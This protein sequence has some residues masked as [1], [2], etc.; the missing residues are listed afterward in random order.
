MGTALKEIPE[1]RVPPPDNIVSR[2]INS[3]TG[4]ST[5]ENDPDSF[6]EYFVMGTEPAPLIPRI[7]D[8]FMTEDRRVV[9]P[10]PVANLEEELF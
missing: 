5:L 1:K 2:L 10:K 9:E 6:T 7:A 3:N 8:P 4:R